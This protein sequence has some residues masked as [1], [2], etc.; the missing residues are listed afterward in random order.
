M[1]LGRKKASIFYLLSS[2]LIVLFFVKSTSAQTKPIPGFDLL[3]YH[4]QNADQ[5]VTQQFSEKELWEHIVSFPGDVLFLPLRIFFYGLKETIR[6]ADDADLLKK[7]NDLFTADDGSWAITPSYSSRTGGGIDYYHFVSDTLTSISFSA[8]AGL[9]RRQNYSLGYEGV[10]LFDGNIATDL[11]VKYRLL[12]DERFYGIGPDSKFGNETNYAHEQV[13]VSASISSK[14]NENLA[15]NGE[16]AVER[17]N[18]LRGRNSATP[19]TT[20]I[21]RDTGLPGMKTGLKFMRL[22]LEVVQDYRDKPGRTTGGG[23]NRFG[24]G[25]VKEIDGD[26]FGFWQ[27]SL[28]AR[29]YIHL[30]YNR[31]LVVRASGIITEPFLDRSIP[32]YYLSD[33]GRQET[34]RG[35]KRGRFRDRDMAFASVEYRFPVAPTL[36]SFIFL[37]SGQVA[38]DLVKDFSTDD[39]QFGYG[40]GLNILSQNRLAA[41]FVIGKSTDGFRVYFNLNQVF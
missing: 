8:S 3:K 36:D 4:T 20:T 2:L 5:E 41:Q 11:E 29:K 12:S 9:R 13:S 19:S 23:I 18:I 1:K 33:L 35:F 32:F 6:Y 15:F 22:N 25:I 40:W 34:I 38:H 37:D 16:V 27:V 39:L 21:F 24:L 14:V 31:V 17:N 26:T 7:S 10:T 28:D 30:F